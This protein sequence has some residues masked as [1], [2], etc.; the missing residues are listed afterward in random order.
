MTCGRVPLSCS[1][2]L[3]LFIKFATWTDSVL[4]IGTVISFLLNSLE[5]ARQC[6]GARARLRK[7]KIRDSCKMRSSMFIVRYSCSSIYIYISDKYWRIGDHICQ[8][9]RVQLATETTDP[10]LSRWTR[11]CNDLQVTE[12]NYKTS[13]AVIHHHTNNNFFFFWKKNSINKIKYRKISIFKLEE[14]KRGQLQYT[15]QPQISLFCLSL[16]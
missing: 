5:G 6:C 7:L 13:P 10:T 2:R 8:N 11:G 14:R 3:L 4:S 1:P 9:S 15:F 16:F 12:T